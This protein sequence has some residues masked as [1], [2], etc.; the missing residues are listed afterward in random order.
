MMPGVVGRVRPCRRLMM[1]APQTGASNETCAGVGTIQNRGSNRWDALR[2]D[3]DVLAVGGNQANG[4]GRTQLTVA[5]S[6]HR[7]SDLGPSRLASSLLLDRTLRL[8]H[9]TDATLNASL[10]GA[11]RL[12]QSGAGQLQLQGDNTGLTGERPVQV[13]QGL[14]QATSLNSLPMGGVLL[15][16]G[17]TLDVNED[18]P[19]DRPIGGAGDVGFRDTEDRFVCAVGTWAQA[20]PPILAGAGPHRGPCFRPCKRFITALS[21]DGGDVPR[22]CP[23][24]LIPYALHARWRSS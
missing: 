7:F 12:A 3:S 4:F 5:P 19:Q 18:N 8:A 2:V 6:G 13:Q 23:A 1:T 10:T 24:S 15:T 21:L 14:L 20:D 16:H 11:A 17:G 22:D 9:P